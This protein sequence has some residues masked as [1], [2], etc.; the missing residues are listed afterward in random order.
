MSDTGT[1]TESRASE[2]RKIDWIELISRYG[3]LLAL[4]GCIIFF[5]TQE[6]SFRTYDNFQTTLEGAAPLMMMALG[7]TVVLV[8]GDF[9]LSVSGMVAVASAIVIATVVRTDIPWGMAVLIALLAALIVGS[10]NGYLV[11]YVGTPSFITT[12]ATGVMLAGVELAVTGPGTTFI[13]GGT[14]IPRSYRDLGIGEPFLEIKTPVWIALAMAVTLWLLLAKTEVGRFMYAIGGN[15]EAARLSGIR[16]KFLRASGFVVVAICASWAGIVSSARTGSH[17]RGVGGSLLLSAFAAAFLGA[18]MSKRLQFNV[19][20]T[21]IGALFLQVVESG[22]TFM[23]YD[24][25]VK[26]IVKGAILIAAMLLG[27][28]GASKR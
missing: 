13:S 16:V 26:N 3:V 25:D 1:A 7:L 5:S 2:G 18:T 28:L 4:V 9:D 14:E 27:R 8:M 10:I 11:S 19:W 17:V 15:P 6:E 12:L 21:V 20:G 24:Q 22:L 23:G